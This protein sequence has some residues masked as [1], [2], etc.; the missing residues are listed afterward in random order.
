M[1]TTS[2]QSLFMDIFAGI[3]LVLASFVVH[4]TV[5]R[6]VESHAR[7]IGVTR[8]LGYT[9]SEIQRSY[10][11]PLCMMGFVLT[12]LGTLARI[13]L[14]PLTSQL[15]LDSYGLSSVPTQVSIPT[16]V[17]AL[18]TGPM[19]VFIAAYVPIRRISGY[20]PARAIR[21][22]VMQP[23]TVRSILIE[24]GLR[25]IGVRGYIVKY[26]A[27]GLSL[28]RTRTA[29]MVLGIALGAGLAGAMD[30]TAS[31]MGSSIDW[32]MD[33]NEHWDLL[34]DFERPL[35]LN[36]A[37]SVLSL[38]QDIDHYEPFL[39]TGARI[40]APSGM[41]FTSLVCIDMEGALHTLDVVDGS[42]PD[43]GTEIAIASQTSMYLHIGLHD[44]VNL[45]LGSTTERL[46]VSARLSCRYTSKE[47]GPQPTAQ[48]LLHFTVRAGVGAPSLSDDTNAC[49]S[50]I[51]L[52]M[53][54]DGLG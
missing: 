24:R 44:L 4:S 49:D 5:K 40:E 51:R 8:A 41:R 46:V 27:R 12:L 1:D 11:I 16:V 13:A 33:A 28:N 19:S 20:E 22:L 54:P 21:G 48:P 36:E 53:E 23:V 15:F 32:Y 7:H 50:A 52:T 18:I 26:V 35:S 39:K 9:T 47:V 37:Q 31:N 43:N 10:L 2:P 3:I 34:V 6:L 45:T 14:G 17:L 25:L 42:L 38:V 29:L 30:L